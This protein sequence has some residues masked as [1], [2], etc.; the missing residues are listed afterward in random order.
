MTA[1]TPKSVLAENFRVSP[2]VFEAI[3]QKEKYIFQASMPKSIGKEQPAEGQGIKK[4]KLQFTH[5]LLQQEPV[6]TSGGEVRIADSKTTFPLSKTIAA[7]HLLLQ[8]GSMREMH[9]HPR[10]MNG[11]SLLEVALVLL[12]S[13]AKAPQELSI[14]DQEMLVSSQRI[15]VTLL[16][17]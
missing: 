7:A 10:P 1:H 15:W 12:S 8:P 13:L 5:R 14:T 17:T 16:R 11:R 3:P 9:W 6:K 4:S 2:E